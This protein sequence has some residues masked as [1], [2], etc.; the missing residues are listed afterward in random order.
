MPGVW[1]NEALTQSLSA[2]QNGEVV[3]QSA[4]V[5]FELHRQGKTEEA[6]AICETHLLHFPD[7][8]TGHLI[9]ARLYH[10]KNRLEEA[11]QEY[12]QVL[13][14]DPENVA[15]LKALGDIFLSL[16]EK[17]LAFGQD[18]KSVV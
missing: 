11:R 10:E 9:L 7:Y 3:P 6:V 2:I 12:G 4:R 16:G 8:A 18:R 17:G 13:K 1:N 5:A 15:A 14:L